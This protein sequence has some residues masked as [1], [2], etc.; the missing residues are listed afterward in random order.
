MP[1]FHSGNRPRPAASIHADALTERLKNITGNKD[2]KL[3]GY[4]QCS[5]PTVEDAEA[6]ATK[7]DD[8]NILCEVDGPIVYV[9]PAERAKI[10]AVKIFGRD[11]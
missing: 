6:L 9:D 5:L 4:Y 2:W 11:R 8:H 3:D 7:L 10:L 1:A